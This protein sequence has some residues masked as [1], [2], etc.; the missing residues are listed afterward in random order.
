M[1]YVAKQELFARPWQA[2]F[3]N[4]LGAFPVARGTSDENM[5]QTAKAILARGDIVLI[6]AEGTRIRPGTL[7]R[8]KRGIGRLALETGVPVVPIAV[9]GTEAIRR[10]WRIR[11]HKVRMRAGRALR[12]P[13]VDNPSPQLAGAVTDR[14]WPCVMLQWEWLG[15]LAPVRRVAV[16]GAG[17]WG[18]SLATVLARGGLEVELG[19]RTPE[20]VQEITASGEN[21]RYLPSVALPPNVTVKRA[22]DL[23]L[24][25]HDLVCLA[26][27][28]GAL[29]A[30][31][32][33]H[34]P[35]IS[36]RMGVL[37]VADGLVPPLGT[38]PAAF[39]AAHCDARAVAALGGPVQSTE[40]LEHGAPV[41][42]AS[43]DRGFARQLADMLSTAKLDASLTTDV[44]RPLVGLPARSSQAA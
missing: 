7:G 16:I 42:V 17:A 12:F 35:N 34:G 38:P 29:P 25:D 39:V 3:L 23:D 26:V 20:Q 32:A 33:E 19:C 30:V 4:A 6:F 14:I 43:L 15:G 41:V 27:P 40:L 1:Y 2:W 28:A 22:A 18:T 13:Q 44:T 5:I 36:D 10:G 21:A 9:I 31:M 8:P 37:V 11:P 24:A